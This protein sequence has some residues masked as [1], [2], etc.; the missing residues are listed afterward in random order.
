MLDEIGEILELKMKWLKRGDM[1]VKFKR[2]E[3]AKKA[4]EIF[5]GMEMDGT[6]LQVTQV[7]QLLP[8]FKPKFGKV[9]HKTELQM[10]NETED[11]SEGEKVSGSDNEQYSPLAK[12][13]ENENHERI[14]K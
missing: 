12:K 6:K 3:S 4:M 10:I 13:L 8:S 14:E 9:F 1:Q 2:E 11:N 5:D 7:F